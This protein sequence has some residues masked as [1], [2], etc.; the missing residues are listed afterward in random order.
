MNPSERSPLQ[1]GASKE[2]RSCHQDD[3]TKIMDLIQIVTKLLHQIITIKPKH[4]TKFLANSIADLARE[5]YQGSEVGGST[6]ITS[7]Y[8]PLHGLAERTSVDNFGGE[9]EPTV[10]QEIKTIS[11]LVIGLGGAG[12][13]TLISALKGN[14]CPS[15]K[16]TLGFCPVLMKYGKACTVQF[17]DIGGGPKIRGIWK[18][19]FH[20]VHGVIYVFDISCKDDT[21]FEESIT[22]AKQTL[23]NPLL[24]GKPLLVICNKKDDSYARSSEVIRHNILMPMSSRS[25]NSIIEISLYPG[26][27]KSQSNIEGSLEWLFTSILDTYNE[28]SERVAWDTEQKIQQMKQ[29]QVRHYMLWH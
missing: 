9:A 1:H 3:D 5:H 11:I 22:V 23:E 24:N 29:D 14:P 8:V 25:P 13:S 4:P 6:H 7:V 27:D 16:P 19:Y 26:G 17:F 10:N 12:K 18:N 20:D 21:L 15:C 2:R 28:L